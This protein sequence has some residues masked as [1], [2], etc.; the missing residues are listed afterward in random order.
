MIEFRLIDMCSNYKN[1]QWDK[2]KNNDS[3]I[4]EME[5]RIHRVPKSYSF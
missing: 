5:K 3:L 1:M 4:D 2:V